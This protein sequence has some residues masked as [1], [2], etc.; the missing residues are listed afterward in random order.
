MR[1]LLAAV[2]GLGALACG[3]SGGSPSCSITYMAGQTMLLGEFSV[4]NQTLNQAPSSLPAH[5]A[6]RMAA[7]PA[8]PGVVGRSDSGVVVGVDA[9]PPAS[10]HPAF[11][12]LVADQNG[13]ARGVMLYEGSIIQNAPVVGEVNVGGRNIPLL[14]IQLD[15]GKIE[16][17]RCP[18]FPDSLSR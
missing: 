14:A 10:M 1:L 17:P 2:L 9:A 8:L 3:S 6:V 18:L 7:G 16:D 13:Q 15:P 12:V 11:G 4:P 5:L